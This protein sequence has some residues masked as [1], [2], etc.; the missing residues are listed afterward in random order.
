MCLKLVFGCGM[1][2]RTSGWRLLACECWL[3]MGWECENV[4][5]SNV[6]GTFFKH[7]YTNGLKSRTI[8]LVGLGRHTR[9]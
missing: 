8:L 9:N 2:A 6:L 3:V 1:Q 5:I 7:V 4:Y